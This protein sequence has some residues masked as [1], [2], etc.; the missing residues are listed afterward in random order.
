MIF[1]FLL[2]MMFNIWTYYKYFT[3]YNYDY[4]NMICLWHFI[5]T[6][7]LLNIIINDHLT[8]TI[9]IEFCDIRKISFIFHQ[10]FYVHHVINFNNLP[11]PSL[12][13]SFYLHICMYVCMYVCMYYVRMYYVRMYVCTHI[14]FRTHRGNISKWEWRSKWREDRKTKT[15]SE[16][17]W[18]T[19]TCKITKWIILWSNINNIFAFCIESTQAVINS[20]NHGNCK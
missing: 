15:N 4:L 13:L 6:F 10:I 7:A 20:T 18:F 2:C 16:R 19:T 12:L 9:I 11:Y 17:I 14:Y 3:Y 5:C 1:Y 8:I